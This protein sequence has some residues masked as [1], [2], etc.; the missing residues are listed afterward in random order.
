M[1]LTKQEFEE[2]CMDIIKQIVLRKVDQDRLGAVAI[3]EAMLKKAKEKAKELLNSGKPV[4]E[5]AKANLE[6]GIR[7]YEKVVEEFKGCSD[8]EYRILKRQLF[9]ED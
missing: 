6:E 9:S 8:E 7:V 1:A 4:P 5:K 3:S 2:K